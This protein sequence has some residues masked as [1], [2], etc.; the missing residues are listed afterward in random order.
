[1]VISSERQPSRFTCLSS[2]SLNSERIAHNRSSRVHN[3]VFT[4]LNAINLPELIRNFHADGTAVFSADLAMD[5]ARYNR[6]LPALPSAVAIEIDRSIAEGLDRLR[7]ERAQPLN[8]DGYD[9]YFQYYNGKP[10]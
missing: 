5:N 3:T 1:M 8:L 2:S 6:I 9:R 4:K 7:A 10:Y